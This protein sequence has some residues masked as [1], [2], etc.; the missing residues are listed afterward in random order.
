VRHPFK[1]YDIAGGPFGSTYATLAIILSPLIGFS[2]FAPLSIAGQICVSVLLDH[3]GFL[4]TQ[5]KPLNVWKALSL[6]LIGGGLGVTLYQAAVSNRSTV[7]TGTT[8]LLSI[9]AFGA[10][11]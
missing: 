2:V 4:G 6:C 10:G 8:V 11:Q 1:W 9:A 3:I 7:S 5:R